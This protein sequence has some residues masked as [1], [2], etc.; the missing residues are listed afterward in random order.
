MPNA[1]EIEELAVQIARVD[2]KVTAL[3]TV[4]AGVACGNSPDE[5]IGF[6]EETLGK[7]GNHF[8]DLVG[9][10]RNPRVEAFNE[11]MK[12]MMEG[13]GHNLRNRP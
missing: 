1:S 11:G 3:A 2:G 9:L 5:L 7:D 13:L 10:P 6:I 12:Q 8:T 4:I